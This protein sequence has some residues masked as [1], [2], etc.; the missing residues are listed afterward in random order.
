LAAIQAS[1]VAP[2]AR[3]EPLRL[4]AAYAWADAVLAGEQE[5]RERGTLGT[6]TWL[7]AEQRVARV[8]MQ[9]R[10]R[11]GASARGTERA[12]AGAGS[13]AR[14]GTEL[15]GVQ[16]VGASSRALLDAA[17]GAGAGL[18]FPAFPAGSGDCCAPKLLRE[19]A[20]RGVRPTGLAEFWYGSPPNT[21]TPQGRADAR[22]HPSGRSRSGGGGSGSSRGSEG[23]DGSGDEAGSGGRGKG[24]RRREAAAGL[25][26]RHLTLYGPCERCER[27]VGSLLCGCAAAGAAD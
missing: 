10:E 7:G 12:G 17:G 4:L 8:E 21:A 25:T 9:G 5:Q 11:S 22:R 6:G 3:G 27:L 14:D 19:A 16:V 1:Y 23:E 15:G 2:N 20:Q 24:G 13:A 26:R 18:A